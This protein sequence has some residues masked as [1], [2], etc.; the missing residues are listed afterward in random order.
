MRTR[1]ILCSPLKIL[2]SLRTPRS[3]GVR[4]HGYYAFGVIAACLAILTLMVGLKGL[5]GTGTATVAAATGGGGGCPAPPPPG[6]TTIV[7]GPSA[8]CHIVDGSF[9]T[10]PAG[11]GPAGAEWS[12]IASLA[13]TTTFGLANIYTD[14]GGGGIQLMYDLTCLM[15]P[16]GTNDLPTTIHF[17]TID[18]S[19]GNFEQY[20]VV[21]QGNNTFQVLVNGAPD[22]STEGIQAKVGF[23]P[24]PATSTPHVLIE[25]SAPLNVVYSPDVALFWTGFFPQKTTGGSGGGGYG[26]VSSVG[27][28]IFGTFADLLVSPADALPTGSPGTAQGS[29]TLVFTDSKTGKVTVTQLPLGTAP[30][31]TTPAALCALAAPELLSLLNPTEE[32][33]ENDDHPTL[34]RQAR[35]Q[36]RMLVAG[37]GGE[38]FK[39]TG[40]K[41]CLLT[42]VRKAC[43][44]TDDNGDD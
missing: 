36:V 9:D 13:F 29:E 35:R 1:K 28:R 5:S 44:V 31:N 42:S 6:P 34:M 22:T 3:E 39:T 14:T 30:G 21:V 24:S 33:C 43:K 38:G 20:D 8:F 37:L 12:D 10:C 15:N 27:E 23:G 41:H 18:A 26:G 32:R 4:R 19:T 25:L 16:Y 17:D 40:L 7:A 11:P 2:R